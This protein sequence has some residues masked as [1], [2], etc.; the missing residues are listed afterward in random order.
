MQKL[1]QIF[2]NPKTAY[3]GTVDPAFQELAT[4]LS[5]L[6]ADR[7]DQGGAAVVVYFR[8]EKVVDLYLGQQ[9]Q[10][11]QVA[12]QLHLSVRQRRR[13]MGQGQGHVH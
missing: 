8:G 3:H 7:L 11:E 6:Q 13:G 10:D 12:G 2:Q 5:Q 9:G 1:L 4:C